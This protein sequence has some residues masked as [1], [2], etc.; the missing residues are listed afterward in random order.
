M[1]TQPVA[2]IGV[3]V[4]MLMELMKNQNSHAVQP[5]TLDCDLIVR[6]S[7]GP[8][9]RRSGNLAAGEAVAEAITPFPLVKGR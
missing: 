7:T 8:A 5:V 6:D 1:I 2:A 9:I 4:D 3:A